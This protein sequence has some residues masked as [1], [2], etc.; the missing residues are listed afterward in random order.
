MKIPAKITVKLIKMT[1]NDATWEHALLVGP[2]VVA[3]FPEVV[4]AMEAA[5]DGELAAMDGK[6]ALSPLHLS[7]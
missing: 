1:T 6:M 5:M 2:V 7:S 4:A 3:T